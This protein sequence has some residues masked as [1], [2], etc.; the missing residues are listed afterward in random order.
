[1]KLE[2]SIQKQ[3]GSFHLDVSFATGEGLIGLLGASGCGKSMTL[4]CIAGLVTPDKGRI[5][6]NDRVLFDRAKRINLPPQQRC[7]GY[8]FQHY[9][10]FPNMTVEQNIISGLRKHGTQAAG[11]SELLQ[12]FHLEEV[13]GNYPCQLS[14]G[15]QQRVALARIL[16]G[17]PE[18]LLLDEPFS[19]L[20]SYLKWQVELEF[21]ERLA[22]V[23]GPVIFVTHARDEIYRLCQRVCV[24]ERGRAEPVQSVAELLEAPTTRSACLLSG[25]KNISRAK[26]A[27]DGRVEALDW[28]V[29]LTVDQPIPKGF[30]HIGIRA[31]HIKQVEGPSNAERNIM[32]CQV[33]RVVEDVFSTIIM[34]SVRGKANQLSRLR[35]ELDKAAWAALGEPWELA[36]ELPPERLMLLQ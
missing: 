2:V 22:H 36:V 33:D 9:A 32:F 3:M 34:L 20:D 17:E 26:N 30:S 6:L 11:V 13:K 10:L 4:K 12:A 8:L 15:Q 27:G 28:G 1:M 21:M 29:T 7:V 14:G 31:H 25:C 23:R 5:V 35:M 19:A 16:V 24:L 18:G